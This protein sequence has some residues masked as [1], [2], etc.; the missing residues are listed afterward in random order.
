M[1]LQFR[2]NYVKSP[3]LNSKSDDLLKKLS[4]MIPGMVFQFQ[5]FSDGK[6]CF[7]YAS[8]GMK[9]LIAVSPEE[10]R[11][12]ATAVFDRVHPEDILGLENSIQESSLTLQDWKHECRI[13]HP[14]VGVRWVQGAA[15]PEPLDD[16]SIVWHGY[17]SDFTD[18]KGIESELLDK[19]RLLTIAEKVNGM[20]VYGRS[21]EDIYFQVCNIVTEHGGLKLAWIGLLDPEKKVLVPIARSG[22]EVRYLEEIRPITVTEEAEGQGP[23]GIAFRER[24]TV[25]NN[26]LI[27]NLYYG[28]WREQARRH[29]FNSSI[30]LPL[31]VQGKVIGTFNIYSSER[32]YFTPNEVLILETITENMS[33]AIGILEDR[34]RLVKSEKNFRTIFDLAP[35]GIILAHSVTGEIY[36]IND[37]FLEILGRTRENFNVSNWME[38]THPDDIERDVKKK[39]LLLEKKIIGFR[40][41]RRYL[42]PDKS[43]VWV[44][45][46]VV[47]YGPGDDDIPK[48][49]IMAQDVS[50]RIMFEEELHKSIAIKD[51]FFAIASHELKTPTTSL[52]LQLQML[53]RKLTSDVDMK[54]FLEKMGQG[55]DLCTTQVN[56]LSEL[57]N[58]LLE[59][60]NFHKG[61]L[62]ITP[63]LFDFSHLLIDV[64]HRFE[65]IFREKC[66]DLKFNI[67]PGIYGTFDRLRIEQV[68]MNLMDN[69]A[70]YAPGRTVAIE[71]KRDKDRALITV[72]DQG[73][74]IENAKLEKI[75]DR[76]ERLD[77]DRN[78]GGLGLGLY[79]AKNIVDAHVG[80]ISVESTVGKGTT[81]RILL[82]LR[83]L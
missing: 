31:I 46:L 27:N 13:I 41:T 18:R 78:V 19:N 8:E 61:V 45:I 5:L 74:G 54:N 26:D 69:A 67:E 37:R 64:I 29:G 72:K 63:E 2:K 58:H 1:A 30:A 7:P 24:K 52:K 10:V 70:K 39:D 3:L 40:S 12:D 6:S 43:T 59:V 56:R 48:N 32:E 15:R 62:K 66:C 82:P 38:F 14:V 81:F 11:E 34:K 50:D 57:V 49:L 60:V 65:P 42:R 77:A 9:D 68:L 79:I 28:P 83:S 21:H 23:S 4:Q 44:D 33:F 55:L 16:G 20:I 75:F 17:V 76:F 71:L 22:S 51:E 35:M 47:P 53:R 73:Q 25:V 80:E 36:Q